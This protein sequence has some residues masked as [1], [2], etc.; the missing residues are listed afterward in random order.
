MKKIEEILE[1]LASSIDNTAPLLDFDSTF[2]LLV[3]VILSA[4]TTDD[5][6]N[7]VTPE[8]F[9]AYPDPSKLA[10][11]EI[12]DLERI[13][14]STGF[15]RA[16][17]KNIKGASQG[18][19]ERY[20]GE[21]PGTIEELTSLPGVGRKS[22][23]VVLGAIFGRPAIIVDTHFRRVSNRL[24]LTESSNPERIERDL[25]AIV[26]PARQYDFSMLVNRHGRFVCMARKPQCGICVLR[27]ICPWPMGAKSET[28]YQ[29]A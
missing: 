26:P 13:V 3:S 9:S 19:I 23:N 25:A 10:N 8:L 1:R 15:F 17:A 5:Q 6:V 4:Q 20:G 27:S 18:L 2:Q 12:E 22:A 29:G 28:S 11:A 7:S 14:H 21:V 16:K 24:G